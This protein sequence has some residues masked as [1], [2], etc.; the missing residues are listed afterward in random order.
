MKHRYVLLLALLTATFSAAGQNWRP[1]RPNG[2]VH[3]F[4]LNRTGTVTD[5]VLTLRLDSAGVRGTDSVYFFNRIM[6]PVKST[7]TGARWRKSRNNQFGAR[8]RYEAAPR[9][10]WLEWAAEASEPARSIPLPVF[11]KAGTTFT[12]SSG[13]SATV[14]SRTVREFNG[15]SDSVATLRVGTETY[16]LSKR[17]GLL[18]GPQTSKTGLTL[19]RLPTMAGL[20]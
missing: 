7:S 11:G 10:Y 12:G 9:V 15:Q 5:S 17:Y 13:T 4:T 6:R 16:E 3:A 8:L 18:A 14:V 20:S 19:A 2:D 1:F